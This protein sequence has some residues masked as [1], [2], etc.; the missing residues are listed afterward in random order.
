MQDKDTILNE[1]T[2]LKKAALSL[3]L[4]ILLFAGFAALAY[5]SLFGIIETRFYNPSVS[6]AALKEAERDRE[7][8][9]SYFA[10]LDKSFA[11]FIGEQA[12]RR[13]FLPNRNEDDIPERDRLSALLGE[14]QAGLRSIR[15]IDGDGS[16]IHYST[17][18]ED[19]LEEGNPPV[20]R[21]YEASPGNVPYESLDVFKK[22]ESRLILDGRGNRII[23]SYPFFDALDLYRGIAVFTLSSSSLSGVLVDSGRLR[24][25][26]DAVILEDPPG[27]VL[28]LPPAGGNASVYREAEIRKQ[29]RNYHKNGGL[30]RLDS[31]G[32]GGENAPLVLVSSQTNDGIF[33]GRI[34]SEKPFVFSFSMKTVLLL[35]FFLT[36]FLTIFLLFNVRA[37]PMTVVHARLRAIRNA[38]V[39]ECRNRKNS[40]LPLRSWELEQRREDLRQEIK[41]TLKIN[42]DRNS[43][44][45]AAAA[46]NQGR[47]SRR[48]AWQ[49]HLE[50][51]IDAYI[52]LVWNEIEALADRLAMPRGNDL[53]G[54][55]EAPREK[56]ETS[57]PGPRPAR[58]GVSEARQAVHERKAPA[59]VAAARQDQAAELEPV[60]VQTAVLSRPLAFAPELNGKPETLATFRAPGGK[61]AA[62]QPA[63][64]EKPA[65]GEPV[66]KNRNGITYINKTY[67]TPDK[68]TAEELD[69]NDKF[70]NLVDSVIND[71]G[72]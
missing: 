24:I 31:G 27:V 53:A 14:K 63:E 3:V 46:G 62:P 15:F 30:S 25:G 16:R 72:H 54:K 5:T 34:M 13:S 19:V 41:R 11:G 56:A 71:N 45:P 68:E 64:T 37:D 44:N 23:F 32:P 60:K 8:I 67:I 61:S 35:L 22:G 51:E 49:L 59:A 17:L 6:R 26:E 58:P 9:Q 21:N 29:A 48:I 69:L 4:A 1:M 40:P 39:E 52:D 65:D 12:L 28:G 7:V 66:F 70:K 57:P 20:Y 38:I 55:W 36:S 2:L 18:K 43:G 33:T 42:P 10:E 47:V 50:R